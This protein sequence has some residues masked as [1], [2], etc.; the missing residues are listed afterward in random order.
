MLW[1]KYFGAQKS[2]EFAKF[3]KKEAKKGRFLALP[4]PHG[5]AHELRCLA[6]RGR[7]SQIFLIFVKATFCVF[8]FFANFDKLYTT[9]ISKISGL[10]CQNC[11][12]GRENRLNFSILKKSEK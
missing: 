4:T 8:Q 10:K 9:E 7:Q 6:M 1:E 5:D 3:L 2:P 11:P 12:Q